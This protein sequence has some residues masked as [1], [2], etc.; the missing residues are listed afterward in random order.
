MTSSAVAEVASSADLAGDITV[1]VASSAAAGV[2]SPTDI[3]EV[4]SSADLAEVASSADLAE[5]ASSAD[6]AGYVTVIVTSLANPASV[7][8]AGMA[9]QE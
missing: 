6:L 4:A 8:T 9:F 7:V 1:G 2:A 5:V 3:A